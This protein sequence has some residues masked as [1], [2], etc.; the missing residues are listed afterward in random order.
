MFHC[1]HDPVQWFFR[2]Q[3]HS[4]SNV[5]EEKY[6]KLTLSISFKHRL[7]W[8]SIWLNR[9]WRSVIIGSIGSNF[10][11]C[12]TIV[13]PSSI[14]KS[15]MRDL[16]RLNSSALTDEESDLWAPEKYI[17]TVWMLQMENETLRKR[18]YIY[19]WVYLFKFRHDKIFVIVGCASTLREYDPII[20][21]ISTN[22]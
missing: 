5:T 18:L 6:C 14:C 13:F 8:V 17:M 9:D 3:P 15:I 21:A 16:T 22:Q 7:T 20:T 1:F 12:P 11:I 19:T 4:N 10:S 2:L